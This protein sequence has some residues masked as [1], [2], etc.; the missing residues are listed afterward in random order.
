MRYPVAGVTQVDFALSGNDHGSLAGGEIDEPKR[1]KVVDVLRLEIEAD[2]VRRLQ[3]IHLVFGFAFG[4]I[5]PGDP[6]R[7]GIE[8]EEPVAIDRLQQVDTGGSSRSDAAGP[9]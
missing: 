3:N 8:V 2:D 6:A 1:E 9:A 7:V 5:E 4:R